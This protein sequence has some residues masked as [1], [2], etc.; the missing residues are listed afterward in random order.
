MKTAPNDWDLMAI[1]GKD[2]VAVGVLF[3][4]HRHFVFRVA[5][6]LLNEDAAADDVVQDV[7][8]KLSAGRLT[9]KPKAKFTTWLYGVAINT[10]REHARKRRRL[11][12]NVSEPVALDAVADDQAGAE[13]L[14]RL[15]DLCA[16]LSHLP[17]RQRE[18]VVLRFLEGFDTAETA[19]ILGCREGTVKAHLHRA[20]VK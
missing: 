20:T 18:V 15:K 7:F 14:E 9:A 6:G 3:S 17:L 1:A 4:R 16:G 13:R 10:A 5:W 8:L 12:G 11:W 2:P 19:A